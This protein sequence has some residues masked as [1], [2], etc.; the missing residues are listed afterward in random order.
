[1]VKSICLIL[2]MIILTGC[3]PQPKRSTG[4]YA[5]HYI[6]TPSYQKSLFKKNFPYILSRRLYILTK[7]TYHLANSHAMKCYPARLRLL[8]R[9]GE[10]IAQEIDAGLFVAA[11]A[12]LVLYRNNLV[13]IRHLNTIN[14][15]P[16]P[17]KDLNW[18]YL[19]SRDL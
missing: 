13:L 19:K 12:D 16:R 11:R 2:F 18:E 3:I 8:R 15:C 9:L 1:M 5:A 17:K 14:G 7:Q 6:F 10:R 4:G